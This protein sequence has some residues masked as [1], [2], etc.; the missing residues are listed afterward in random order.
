MLLKLIKYEFKNTSLRFIQLF[1]I[2]IAMTVVASFTIRNNVRVENEFGVIPAI[3]SL[4]TGLWVV[5]IIVVY[6]LSFILIIHRFYHS[7][8]GRGAYLSYSIPAKANELVSAKLI[9]GFV[10]YILSH[11]VITVSI[12]VVVFS[13]VMAAGRL[14]NEDIISAIGEFTVAERAFVDKL[15]E[16]LIIYIICMMIC[17]IYG[18][19]AWYFG[20]A[21]GMQATKHRV[22]FMI[23][24]VIGVGIVMQI[25][26][27]LVMMQDIFRFS[28]NMTSGSMDGINMVTNLLEIQK[29]WLLKLTLLSIL[30]AVA[31]YI[32]TVLLIKK[33]PNIV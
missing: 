32:G 24:T 1:L 29:Q 2:A 21:V 8:V 11:L 5:T 27:N 31:S 20:A 7:M 14:Y 28:L 12:A 13:A 3:S 19:V 15:G 22:G 16:I 17:S 6:V 30:F 10:W 33:R 4:L 9:A 18:I 25:V 26:S 23:L